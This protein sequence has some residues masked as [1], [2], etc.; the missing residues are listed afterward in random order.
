MNKSKYELSHYY[1]LQMKQSTTYMRWRVLEKKLLAL[2]F[3]R[4]SLEKL[5]GGKLEYDWKEED[6]RELVE[7]VWNYFE[8]ESGKYKVD[9]PMLFFILL[10]KRGGRRFRV[11]MRDKFVTVTC[12]KTDRYV[13]E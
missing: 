12:I 13:Y 3:K 8:G 1:I 2:G 9:N 5:Y 11:Y 6:A 4:K 7:K 10:K